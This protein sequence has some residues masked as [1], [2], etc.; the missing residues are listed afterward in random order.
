LFIEI[1]LTLLN[2]LL[3]NIFS[4]IYIYIT[5]KGAMNKYAYERYSDL[6]SDSGDLTDPEILLFTA[7]RKEKSGYRPFSYETPCRGAT[8]KEIVEKYPND[9]NRNRNGIE[10]TTVV[11]EVK[12]GLQSR[13]SRT[14]LSPLSHPPTQT[15]RKNVVAYTEICWQR[16]LQ[17]PQEEYEEEEEVEEEEE[18]D[19]D[20]K[21]ENCAP[22][23]HPELLVVQHSELDG[24]DVNINLSTGKSVTTHLVEDMYVSFS[25]RSK[26]EKKMSE[27][28]S[29]KPSL[30]KKKL[31][32]YSEYYH[33]SAT[34]ESEDV[35]RVMAPK[36]S[37]PSK[38][39][40]STIKT[41]EKVYGIPMPE[42]DNV[43]LE[44]ASPFG[45]KESGK[46]C[47]NP[48]TE[49]PPT[50]PPNTNSPRKKRLVKYSEFYREE[51]QSVGL[52]NS[53]VGQEESDVFVADDFAK[54]SPED[55][56]KQP[57]TKNSKKKLV[58]Y[59]EYHQ[60][61]TCLGSNPIESEE[62]GVDYASPLS[63]SHLWPRSKSPLAMS[64][65]KKLIKYS[66]YRQVHSALE[67]SPN[68]NDERIS[69]I[70]YSNAGLS[71]NR[72]GQKRG[73]DKKKDE[74]VLEDI[75]TRDSSGSEK[76]SL[77]TA[78][79]KIEIHRYDIGYSLLNLINLGCNH[80]GMTNLV[81]YRRWTKNIEEPQTPHRT[82]PKYSALKK[83]PSIPPTPYREEEA[84]FWDPEV[85]NNW[86]DKH[87]PQ[88]ILLTS[89]P[90]IS[91]HFSDS[92]L[93]NDDGKDNSDVLVMILKSP[94]KQKEI[95]KKKNGDP[96][97][98]GSK[99][100][101]QISERQARRKWE[102]T[103]TAT[104][105]EFIAE[106]DETLAQGGVTKH[107]GRINV[108]WNA[109]LLT[110]AGRAYIKRGTIELSPKVITD[111][112]MFHLNHPFIFEE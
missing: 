87:S 81:S 76:D 99:A 98:L 14:L 54:L 49:N 34:S 30:K 27:V 2:L 47:T 57:T 37:E 33:G 64:P 89:L 6:D 38:P 10:K 68:T 66:E 63:S 79:S 62:S 100:L 67:S 20:E 72:G 106:L 4:D 18:K 61:H 105:E 46:V 36:R 19:H 75:F 26:E 60:E 11:A 94:T 93:E 84:E 71:T 21:S 16:Q 112:G 13:K 102:E 15:Q 65:K 74:I 69:S 1:D 23:Y 51:P 28:S 77:I 29:N 40:T 73:K 41:Q 59:A 55:L 82:Q 56:E 45:H 101:P 83:N 86:I 9:R 110:T 111:L 52:E 7:G 80:F 96:K 48:G 22:L 90:Y 91:D 8:S 32:R 12:T 3:F 43:R 108:V 31:V 107:F 58:K 39:K 92:D 97:T 95:K 78:F 24:K 53:P 85:Q 42:D 35:E 103:K 17:E 109:R 25:R 70:H 104:A 88:K 50:L 44:E 5:I